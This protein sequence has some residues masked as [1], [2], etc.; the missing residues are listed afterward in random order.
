M[1]AMFLALMLLNPVVV[2]EA[3]E[4]IDLTDSTARLATS[5][6]GSAIVAA[7]VIEGPNGS[8]IVVTYWKAGENNIRCFS[9]IDRDLVQQLPDRCQAAKR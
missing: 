8:Q 5:S 2:A 6:G 1:R 3:A 4:W 7:T 9:A